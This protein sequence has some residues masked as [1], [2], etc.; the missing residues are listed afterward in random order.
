MLFAM[1][2]LMA[3]MI[4][5]RIEMAADL[6]ISR[7]LT[8]MVKG[9][10]ISIIIYGHCGN[11]FGIRY[12]TPL[13][14]IGVALFLLLSGYGINESWIINGRK[15]YWKKRLLTFFMPYVTCEAVS[16]ATRGGV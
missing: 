16:A 10:A 13:G 14:G 1:F 12:L 2:Y 3:S 11:Y 6:P 9:F 7:D 5:K 4:L 8:V 15:G